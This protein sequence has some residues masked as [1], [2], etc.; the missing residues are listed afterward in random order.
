MVRARLTG[1]VQE[2]GIRSARHSVDATTTVC[3]RSNERPVCT[4]EQG[5]PGSLL[6]PTDSETVHATAARTIRPTTE[7]NE[8]PCASRLREQSHDSRGRSYVGPAIFIAATRT[9]HG[10]LPSDNAASR[11]YEHAHFQGQ[12]KQSVTDSTPTFLVY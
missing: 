2:T 6:A 7:S 4:E 11:P 1:S 3:T 10:D 9:K 5:V 12:H 8:L